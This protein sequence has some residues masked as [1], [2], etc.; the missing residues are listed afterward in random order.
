MRVICNSSTV[1]TSCSYTALQRS[2]SERVEVISA[3]IDLESLHEPP[4]LQVQPVYLSIPIP[5]YA[6][7][8][9]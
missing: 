4:D 8:W 5:I 1:Y 2:A 3:N 7:S 9:N 6:N